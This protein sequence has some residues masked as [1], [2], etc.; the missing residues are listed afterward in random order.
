MPGVYA[1]EKENIAYTMMGLEGPYGVRTP[2]D[3]ALAGVMTNAPSVVAKVKGSMT[4]E[5]A[6]CEFETADPVIPPNN[7]GVYTCGVGINETCA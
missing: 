1:E 6:V 3:S 5:N 4:T 2:P 7:T